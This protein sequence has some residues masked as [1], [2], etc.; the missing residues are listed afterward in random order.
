[1]SSIVVRAEKMAAGGDAIARLADGRVAF[2]RGALPG[3]LV[4]IQ[5]VLSKKDFVRAEVLDV[6]EPSAVRTEPPCAGHA[7]GCGGCPWQ[8]VDA[9]AQ[10]DLKVAVVLEALKRTGKM[11][12]PVVDTGSS[13]PAWAY[14]TTLRLATG[15]GDRL[16]LRGRNSHEIVELSGCPVSHPLLEEVLDTVRARGRG[17]VSLRVGSATRQRSAWIVDGDVEL[18]GLPTDVELGPAATVHEVVAGKTLR[19]SARSFFQSGPAAAELLVAA[20]REACGAYAEADSIVDAYGGVGLFGAAL[21][22]RTTTVV[23]GNEAACA[24]AVVNLGDRRAVIACSQVEQWQPRRTDLVVADP[25]RSGLG[26]QAVNVL[27]GTRASRIV[28][29]SCDPVSLAHDAGLFRDS[30]YDHVRS[31]VFDLF[32]QTHHVE[33]VTTFDRSTERG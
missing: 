6:V 9:V 33:V 26:R 7:A 31:T 19:I 14:R 23:E 15:Q 20:V 29:V 21:G 13:V 22:G 5:I 27:A 10:L 16:G 12:D 4:A 28:V 32:P 1:M 17:E 30:G 18:S 3:E 25:S 24:D 11:T 2:V 8:H